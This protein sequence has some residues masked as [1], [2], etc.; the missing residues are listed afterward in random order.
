MEELRKENPDGLLTGL[1]TEDKTLR[2]LG[3]VCSGAWTDPKTG[4]INQ[5][6]LKDFL[7][8]AKRIYE[9]EIAGIEEEEQMEYKKHYE[10]SLNW[11]G[12]MEY[13]ADASS[14]GVSI[15]MGEQKIGLGMVHML[16]GDFNMISTLADQEEDFA[17]GLWQGQI[18]NGFIP[19]G[20]IGIC[21]G[22]QENGPALDFFRFLYGRELQDIE[23]P[24]GLLSAGGLI[25]EKN[26][27]SKWQEVWEEKTGLSRAD[28]LQAD[29]EF[30]QPGTVL[31]AFE[32]S[33]DNASLKE[34]GFLTENYLKM[35]GTAQYLYRLEDMV[36]CFYTDQFIREDGGYDHAF[37]AYST[38]KTRP[39][40]WIPAMQ[41]PSDEIIKMLERCNPGL[42]T[43]HFFACEG[44]RFDAVRGFEEVIDLHNQILER[45]MKQEA[46]R[47]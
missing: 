29:R 39:Y 23:V 13:F 9:A 32:K 14:G 16:D 8:Q 45:R 3:I 25:L 42:V 35:P 37:V 18:Q 27:L 6:K 47:T 4:S 1:T 20:M 44:R 31:L 46:E 2:T 17:F 38:D 26:R 40:M 11:A 19:R 36:A 24:G 34:M 5:E 43:P 33:M 21:N 12:A 15:A 41:E 30:K 28:L 7:T 22:S 10:S